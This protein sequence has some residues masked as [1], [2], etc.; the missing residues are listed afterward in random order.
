MGVSSTA[1]APRDTLSQRPRIAL[2]HAI[3]CLVTLAI[4]TRHLLYPN[5]AFMML[6]WPH[7][8]RRCLMAQVTQ[9]ALVTVDIGRAGGRSFL[10]F[11]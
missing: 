1:R 10:K 11:S 7:D 9:A 8:A 4:V 6:A 2:P 3:H 5:I